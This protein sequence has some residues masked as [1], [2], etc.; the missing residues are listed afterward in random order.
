LLETAWGVDADASQETGPHLFE[1]S[2]AGTAFEYYA[3]SIGA[4]SQSAKTYLEK[5]F[6]SFENGRWWYPAA[7]D[8]ADDR[9]LSVGDSTYSLLHLYHRSSHIMSQ[10]Q[11]WAA[12]LPELINHGLSALADTLQQDKHLTI[13]NTSIAIIGTPDA[14]IEN[15]AAS[16]PAKR[17]FFRVWENDDVDQLLRAWRRSRGE[18][19]DG[20]QEEQPQA[21]GQAGEATEGEGQGAGTTGEGAPPAEHA[22]GEDVTMGE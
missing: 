3:H 15:V 20:P 10:Y 9:V 8:K 5:N 13:A 12:S 11:T 22:A 14:S 21:E 18:P 6:E 16:G 7:W 1:F 17:G 19:E 4:R 2:P